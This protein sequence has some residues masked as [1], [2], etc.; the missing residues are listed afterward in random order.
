MKGGVGK[1]V[2]KSRRPSIPYH[3]SDDYYNLVNIKVGYLGAR[4][5]EKDWLYP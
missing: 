5:R 1:G 2:S 4:R 3:E